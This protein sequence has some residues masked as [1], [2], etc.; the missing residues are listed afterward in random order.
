[1]RVQEGKEEVREVRGTVEA[2][3]EGEKT[4][5]KDLFPSTFIQQ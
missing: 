2:G 3:K 5:F 4:F 1:M